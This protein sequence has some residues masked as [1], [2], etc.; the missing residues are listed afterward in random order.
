MQHQL[1]YYKAQ[2]ALLGAKP[3]SDTHLIP[4]ESQ[5]KYE[6]FLPSPDFMMTD[7]SSFTTQ[8]NDS[9]FSDSAIFGNNVYSFDQKQPDESSESSIP[10]KDS[11]F[12]FNHASYNEDQ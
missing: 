4:L 10:C 2:A 3:N 5:P 9:K 12:S 1:D 11:I 6:D 8:Q 7:D